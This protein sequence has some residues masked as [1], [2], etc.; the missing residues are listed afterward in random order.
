MCS[1]Y[2]SYSSRRPSA[3]AVGLELAGNPSLVAH[4]RG[5]AAPRNN[6]GPDYPWPSV[7][8]RRIPGG[9]AGIERSASLAGIALVCVSTSAP[10]PLR[11][12]LPPI[13]HH[14]L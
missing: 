13:M 11:T 8:Y 6:Q 12:S 7:R 9:T 3:L 2:S 1:T 14:S 4:R 10:R 5:Y